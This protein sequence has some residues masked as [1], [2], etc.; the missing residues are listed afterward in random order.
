MRFHNLNEC[1][2]SVTCVRRGS[3]SSGQVEVYTPARLTGQSKSQA[4]KA[5]VD[6]ILSVTAETNEIHPVHLPGSKD[7]SRARQVSVDW[8]GELIF[9]P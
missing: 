7:K 9:M 4:L 1:S 8:E 2:W 3:S 5:V 6:W